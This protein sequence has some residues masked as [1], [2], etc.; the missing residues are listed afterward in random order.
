MKNT[1]QIPDIMTAHCTDKN[2]DIE[3][4]FISQHGDTIRA[5]Y[6]TIPLMFKRTKPGIYVANMAGL[7]FVIKL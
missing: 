6:E 5:T 3:V 7:E 1:I 2:K 4:L